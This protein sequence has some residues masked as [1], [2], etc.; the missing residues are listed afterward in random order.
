MK[1][2]SSYFFSLLS[3]L[4]LL[5]F[6]CSDSSKSNL[7]DE[8]FAAYVVEFT[9]GVIPLNA[10]IN[11][12]F[13][14]DIKGFTEN[15]AEAP[16]S[17]LRLKPSVGGKTYWIDQRSIRFIPDQLWP[18]DS[19][20]Q[21]T[22]HL[23]QLMDVPQ[24]YHQFQFEVQTL[25]LS[26]EVFNFSLE[27]TDAQNNIYY[28][29]KAKILSS[30]VIETDNLAAAFSVTNGNYNHH[31]SI[32]TTIEKNT[33]SLQLDS[34]M[35]K[36]SP[37]ELVLQW[38][39]KSFG[40]NSVGEQRI[41]IP[42]LG[43]F[44]IL[45]V[46]LERHQEQVI[47]IWFSDPIEE[48]QNLD[49]LI[50]FDPPTAHRIVRTK[51]QLMVYP[52][53]FL[54]GDYD[55]VISAG[56]RNNRM[57]ALQQDFRFPINLNPVKPEV[58]FTGN[59]TILAG[60]G[61]S[62]VSF[63]ARGLKAV[64]VQV[65]QLFHNNILQFLQWNQLD[66]NSDLK[67]VGRVIAREQIVLNEKHVESNDWQTYAVDLDR[68]VQTD[69]A[70]LYRVLIT[71][72]KAYSTFGCE[73]I[74]AFEPEDSGP[75][76]D[77]LRLWGDGY[78]YDP[79]YYYPENFQWNFRDDPC[80]DSYYYFERFVG[81]NI[82]VSNLGLL[83]KQYNPEEKMYIF[84]VNDLTT[85]EPL[86][87]VTIKLYD[88]QQQLLGSGV[89]DAN[90]SVRLLAAEMSPFIAVA[91]H[92]K[93]RAYLKLDEGSALPLSRFD[94]QGTKISQG[95]KGFL[96][97]ERGVYRPGDTVHVGFILKSFN[98]SLPPDYPVTME[99]YN[100]RQ[101]LVS[102]QTINKTADGMG[103]FKI[104]T[105]ADAPTGL[106]Q[107][108]LIAGSNKFS[109]SIR[110][111]NIKPNRL[112][113]SFKPS[114][115]YFISSDDKNFLKLN[116]KW[117]HG[118]V[119]KN[120][121]VL[122]EQKLRLVKPDF[123]GFN[124]YSFTDVSRYEYEPE[125]IKFEGKTD[126][127]GNFTLKTAL[128]AHREFRGKVRLQW[129]A[130]V[131]EPGGDISASSY[132]LDY[133]PFS[134]Y[135]GI[136]TPNTDKIPYLLTDQVQEFEI[137]RLTVDG[138]PQGNIP[139]QLQV[140]RLDWSWWWSGNGSDR[141]SYVSADNAQL[142][143]EQKVNLVGGRGTF[144]WQL[145][146]PEWGNYL[147]K[148]SDPNGG[149][150]ASSIVYMDWP[151]S[152]S[153][154]NRVSG[155]GA[156]IVSISTDKESYVTGENAL[157]SFPSPPEGRALI[158]I[159]NGSMQLK[160]WWVQLNATETTISFPIDD[161]YS[162]NVYLHVTMLQPFGKLGN[163]MP[164]RTYGV[165]PIL[166]ENPQTKLQPLIHLPKEAET[167]KSFDIVI[168]EKSGKGME[169]IVALVDEGL[170]DITNHKTPDP[171]AVFY[172]K[173]SL[174][175]K[176]WDMYDFVLGAYG[177][178]IEQLFSIG[179]DEGMP[180]RNKVKE[181]R[182]DPVVKVIGPYHLK[183][184]STASHPV[185]I[186]NYIGSVRA[187]VVAVSGMAVGSS[188]QEMKIMQ[189]LMVTGTLPRI[190]RPGDVAFLPVTVF[191]GLKQAHEVLVEVLVEGEA[192]IIGSNKQTIQLN[193]S[194]DFDLS[195]RLKANDKDGQIMV[196]ILA[197]S[198]N[199]QA[200]QTI[201][202]QVQNPNQRLFRSEKFILKA[203]EK[204]SK[205]I[206]MYG[207]TESQESFLEISVLP[208]LNLRHRLSN[209]LSYPYG[210]T[211]QIVSQG[212]S[213]LFLQHLIHLSATEKESRLRSLNEVIRLVSA[214]QH[215]SGSINYWPGSDYIHP[216]T[217]VYAGHFMILAQKENF[218]VSDL[219]VQQ[220]VREQRRLALSWNAIA[221]GKVLKNEL[222]QVYRLYVLAL[223]GEAQLNVMN[224]LREDP[225][226]SKD[227][228][229]LLAASYMLAGQPQAAQKLA[230][231]QDYSV[232]TSTEWG[233]TFGSDLRQQAIKLHCMHLLGDET[234]AFLLAQNIAEKLSSNESFN[235]QETAW[236]L[237][238]WQQF[239]KDKQW[240]K[241]ASVVIDQ[242]Q[243]K[244][245]S[246]ETTLMEVPLEIKN[247][248]FEL[249]NSGEQAVFVQF[250][251]SAIPH[252]KEKFAYADGISLDI[253]F[254]DRTGK[255]IDPVNLKQGTSFSM[256]VKVKNTS[257]EKFDFM[258][259]SQFIPA[260][261]EIVNNRVFSAE[262]KG[263]EK[264]YM[265]FKD[266][267]VDH[268]FEI[269][270]GQT[271]SFSIDLI[272]AYQGSYFMPGIRCTAMYH[273]GAGAATNGSMIHVIQ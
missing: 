128:P 246:L 205:Q 33:Y 108:Q 269:L 34:I 96:F 86:S 243:P 137:V 111:E 124:Q 97:T 122:M 156:N 229:L 180:D 215:N 95:I 161:R 23:N 198:G 152:Y 39:G 87:G 94:V 199:Y 224:R 240:D 226:L 40:S 38:N 43:D 26:F 171:H 149:H 143:H 19:K 214:R 102:R 262:N 92:G 107:A 169:Y 104:A 116:V 98:K 206:D 258:A 56:I 159:E 186:D 181:R 146:Y 248:K 237:F 91:E 250:V 132:E 232:A 273:K 32:R 53:E 47:K 239:A 112:K 260:G 187:M 228:S 131:M 236:A 194:S 203:G 110:V 170:L 227:A 178:K 16:G 140:F 218:G 217:E 153:R 118:A 211:E 77:E 184:G 129:I 167:S 234:E 270:P 93:E 267:R 183:A 88:Y 175:I 61:N 120:M 272:A 2:V 66:G 24:N 255:E 62:Q 58:R 208:S 264:A 259:L 242:G 71:F 151:D 59:S 266:D 142:V 68:I 193:A 13:T 252:I 210:C 254:K 195:F 49:G 7:P 130:R 27:S 83:A 251:R 127:Q 75:N 190:L 78:Y 185:T 136:K 241:K 231:G 28:T 244:E 176:T 103:L 31:S 12:S 106:W 182:F 41:Q 249:T 164:L 235:T 133:Y 163:D 64:D 233:G 22:V 69:R 225:R 3:V 221:E 265:D 51:N 247:P 238:A 141:A 76:E 204:S 44:S 168:K 245:F 74:T 158:S 114:H 29:L 50:S 89:T 18:S 48:T 207:I 45:K 25:P 46:D 85:S 42:A 30:D 162:P 115:D 230:F 126:D 196:K 271:K 57:L 155:G 123:K 202:L 117:L 253:H 11:I 20:I 179:G 119:A 135:L 125:S 35:R 139:V 72:K 219:F 90:G 165:I 216:W 154:A 147:I 8:G 60:K 1:I 67:R 82:L 189:P 10:G 105:T 148:I 157:I 54:S 4:V 174:G 73:G 63:Q 70:S 52:E 145:S 134:H 9:H 173:E 37:S 21:I 138:K 14:S 99:L 188:A 209:M 160:S 222:L 223:A 192:E 172:A 81:K 80:N 65:I 100:V 109:R 113:I 6:S 79:S 166:V 191:S 200:N 177:G 15:G 256:E 36:E 263:S 197:K 101:Q 268:F 84:Y 257:S 121:E 55:V 150:A 220:W 261:W 144:N 213:Q 212:F 5:L 17:L 201:N